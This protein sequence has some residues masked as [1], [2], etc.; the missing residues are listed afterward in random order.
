M[1]KVVL[2]TGGSKGIGYA[3]AKSFVQKGCRIYELSRRDIPNPGVIHITG[4]VTDSTSV[5][6]AVSSIIER[7]GKIDILVCNAGTVLSGAVEFTDIENVR[8]LME[9]NL[10]GMIHCVRAVLPHMRLAGSG[11]IV[12]LSSMASAFPIPYQAYYSASKAAV[13]AFAFSLGNEVRH[14]GITVCAILPGDTKTEP[15]RNKCHTGDNVYG[16]RIERSIAVMER[17]ESNGMSPDTV[18]NVISSIALRKRVKPSYSI[19]FMSKIQLIIKRIV[20]E[21]FVQKVVGIMYVK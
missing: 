9:L 12:C 1:S 8:Q 2:L 4:D 5:K 3:T 10:Y 21:A 17:D 13:S 19:G 11:R 7:E 20:S 16:G 6:D 18:G 14:C 15:V